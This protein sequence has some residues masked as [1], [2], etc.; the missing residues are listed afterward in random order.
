MNP[1]IRDCRLYKELFFIPQS[2]SFII[3]RDNYFIWNSH[4]VV[5]AR[6]VDTEGQLSR[7]D[8]VRDEGKRLH[9]R[10]LARTRHKHRAWKKM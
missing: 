2:L 7:V 6:D 9:Q 4:R 1:L 8:G 10:Q 5:Y 3:L